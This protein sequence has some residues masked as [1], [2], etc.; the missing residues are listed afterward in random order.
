MRA[1]FAIANGCAVPAELEQ[2][3]IIVYAAPDP[4]DQQEITET[5]GLDPYDIESAHDPDEISRVEFFPNR[6]S[7]I[8]K[9]PKNAALEHD[10]V[11]FDVASLGLFLARERLVAIMDEEN[12]PFSARE[13]QGV[14]TPVDVF[15]RLLLHTVHHYLGHLKVIKQITTE[16]GAK[17]NTSMENLYLLQMVTLSE[18]LIYYQNAIEANGAVLTRLRGNVERM[19]FTPAQIETL[20]DIELDNQQCARQAQIYSSVLSGLMDARGTIVNNNVNVLLKNLT[21]INI[22]F[23]PLNLIASIGGMSEF[24]MMSHGMDWRLAYAL[25]TLSMVLLGW[26]SWHALTRWLDKRQ[27]RQVAR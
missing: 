25:F 5:L 17:I 16:L 15:L 10:Q 27:N 26:V 13:F 22:I 24:S 2:A 9:R 20:H 3:S 23:L 4:Q 19:A 8:W 21:L 14:T 18:S 7:V 6:V 11:R 1:A 12:L